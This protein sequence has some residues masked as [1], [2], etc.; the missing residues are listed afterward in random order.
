MEPFILAVRSGQSLGTLR[1][2]FPDDD[3]YRKLTTFTFA[4]FKEWCHGGYKY[5]DNKMLDGDINDADTQ[6]EYQ[7]IA[8]VIVE[9]TQ[10]ELNEHKLMLYTGCLYYSSYFVKYLI[11][12]EVRMGADNENSKFLD[13]FYDELEKCCFHFR[14]AMTPYG[15]PMLEEA[16]GDGVIISFNFDYHTRGSLIDIL[17]A[18]K[19]E[20]RTTGA[21]ADALIAF[22]DTAEFRATNRNTG[23]P[24]MLCVWVYPWFRER[25]RERLREEILAVARAASAGA[26]AAGATNDAGVGD[27]VVTRIFTRYTD[28]VAPAPNRFALLHSQ[29]KTDHPC[30]LYF[31]SELEAICAEFDD[32]DDDATD[33]TVDR[34]AVRATV[35]AAMLSLVA[36]DSG[37]PRNKQT[38]MTQKRI[39]R[40]YNLPY[41]FSDLKKLVAPACVDN[42]SVDGTAG[43]GT[44]DGGTTD[45]GAA[46]DAVDGAAVVDISMELRTYL[47][48]MFTDVDGLVDF[49]RRA[50]ENRHP[51]HAV[52]DARG[53]RGPGGACAA[54]V[55]SFL[56]AAVAPLLDGRWDKFI[57]GDILIDGSILVDKNIAGLVNVAGKTPDPVVVAQRTHF[58]RFL[59]LV[60]FPSEECENCEMCHKNHKMVREF[61]AIFI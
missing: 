47:A 61:I 33:R 32:A 11:A 55:T 21:L 45:G 19:P 56:N 58:R 8:N 43:G 29:L 25:V 6:T 30:V 36:Y 26:A 17:F 1:E 13:Q 37:M 57:S 51:P 42:V 59:F 40:K 12:A 23:D 39:S 53:P 44:T 2:K 28:R 35:R 18:R 9:Y 31:E 3:L 48:S 14:P 10:S 34:A 24:F 4:G 5:C 52:F 15:R 38:R 49:V 41:R 54:C 16:A 60:N 46:V 22:I 50:V 20:L 27:L 7:N